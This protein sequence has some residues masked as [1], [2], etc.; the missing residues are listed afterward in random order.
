MNS[1]A[2]N[3]TTIKINGDISDSLS[4][5]RGVR[6]GCPL[7]AS[8]YIVYLQI[9]L[10]ILTADSPHAIKGIDLPGDGRIKVSAHADDLVLFCNDDYDVQKCF[11]FF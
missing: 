5:G 2:G 11:G 6:Q 10:N 1:Y 3:H 9:F 4:I 7:S 8:L